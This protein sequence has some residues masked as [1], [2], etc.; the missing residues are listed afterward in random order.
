MTKAK[1]CETCGTE[2]ERE[3]CEDCAGEGGS[4]ESNCCDDMCNGGATP[5]LHGDDSEYPCGT[6]DGAGG[7]DYCPACIAQP[8]TQGA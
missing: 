6:C 7:W 8:K 3:I 4:G 5:C 1:L 2:L